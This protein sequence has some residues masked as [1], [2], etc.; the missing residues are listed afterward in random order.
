MLVQYVK[1]FINGGLLG[2]VAWV[3]QF[4]I[5]HLIGKDVSFSYAIASGLAYIPLVVVNFIIQ[6]TFIFKKNGF[7]LRFVIANFVV[8]LIVVGLS[9]YCKI[10]LTL[11]FGELWGERGGFV[12]ASILGSVPSFLI[13]RYWV[14]GGI[15]KVK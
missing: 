9:E 13:K 7:F 5:Y 8:M 11:V 3:L 1:F 6:K 14:F 15:S 10:I 12:M 4:L 2:V